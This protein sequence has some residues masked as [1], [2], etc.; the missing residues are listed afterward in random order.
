M[1]TLAPSGRS[2]TSTSSGSS[3]VFVHVTFGSS[4]LTSTPVTVKSVAGNAGCV[5]WIPRVCPVAWTAIV[6]VAGVVTF[7]VTLAGATLSSTAMVAGGTNWQLSQSVLCLF[8]S[9]AVNGKKSARV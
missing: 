6:Y 7:E 5:T 4:A 9:D 3:L 8:G 1:V 2:G